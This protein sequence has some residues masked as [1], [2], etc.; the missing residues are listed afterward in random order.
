MISYC[1]NV[2]F[3]TCYEHPYCC[4]QYLCSTKKNVSEKEIVHRFKSNPIVTYSLDANTV[5]F[6]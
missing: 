4:F 2:F 5:F 6:T 1:R 3:I